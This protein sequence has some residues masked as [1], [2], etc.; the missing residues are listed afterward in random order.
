MIL[1]AKCHAIRDA[2]ILEKKLVNGEMQTEEKRL[3]Q[4]MEV[5]RLN[6]IRMQEEIER[7]R[8]E[9]RL[10]GA[11]QIL[12]QIAD[13]EQERLFELERKDQENIQMQ[14][15]LEKLMEEDR[16]KLERKASEQTLLRVSR[17]QTTPTNL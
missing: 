13:N 7:K 17:R 8:R 11:T 5:D 3:D 15:Y 16:S 12:E 6:A 9:E 14:K 10:V 1:N 2:Q 4:M